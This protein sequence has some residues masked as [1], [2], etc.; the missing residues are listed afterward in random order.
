MT[1]N[2]GTSPRTT[3]EILKKGPDEKP[4]LALSTIKKK[5]KK[6]TVPLED[7]I[8]DQQ[9]KYPQNLA[10]SFFLFFFFFS[11]IKITITKFLGR[12][13]ALKLYR[14]CLVGMTDAWS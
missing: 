7:T 9:E 10:K 4:P 14:L 11:V 8:T 3:V 13:L 6:G 12:I 5:K 2:Q 1:S